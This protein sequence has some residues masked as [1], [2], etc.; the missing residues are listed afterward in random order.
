MVIVSFDE[1][2][3]LFKFKQLIFWE[4]FYHI[5]YICTLYIYL[6]NFEI[7]KR[8]LVKKSCMLQQFF[9]INEFLRLDEIFTVT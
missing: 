9:K 6:K 8:G 7:E 1:M 3:R 4:I 2:I 5:M